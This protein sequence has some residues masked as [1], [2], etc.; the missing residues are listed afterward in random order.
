MNAVLDTTA[1]SAAEGAL[2]GVARHARSKATELPQTGTNSQIDGAIVAAQRLLDWMPPFCVANTKKA[3][4]QRAAHVNRMHK[5][6]A[7]ILEAPANTVVEADVKLHA[8]F[9]GEAM[10]Y[11]TPPIGRQRWTVKRCVEELEQVGYAEKLARPFL[12]YRNEIARL[13]AAE[14]ATPAATLRDAHAAYLEAFAAH[15][16]AL[17]AFGR[18]EGLSDEDPRY[19]AANDAVTDA[20]HAEDAAWNAFI[21]K[22]AVS[23][24]DIAFKLEC[25]KACELMR[26]DPGAASATIDQVAHDVRRLIVAPT[27]LFATSPAF[28]AALTAEIM[29]HQAHD[30]ACTV[31][32]HAEARVFAKEIAE[33]HPDMVAA[34]Q[35]H[36]ETCELSAA[37]F[38]R[39]AE[40]PATTTA[41][42]YLKLQRFAERKLYRLDEVADRPVRPGNAINEHEAMRRVVRDLLRNGP[43]NRFAPP[44]IEPFVQAASS[45]WDAA[46]GRLRAER[47]WLNDNRGL[48]VPPCYFEAVNRVLETPAPNLEALAYKIGVF[49]HDAGIIQSNLNF[50]DEVAGVFPP[51]APEGDEVNDTDAEHL[52]IIYQDVITLAGAQPGIYGADAQ[53]WDRARVAHLAAKT[54]WDERDKLDED[55]ADTLYQAYCD[56]LELF[57]A[58]PPPTVLAMV[59]QMRAEFALGG[60]LSLDYQGADCPLSMRDLLDGGDSAAQFVARFYMH[61]LRLARVSSEALN[62]PAISGMYPAFNHG[63]HFTQL[64]GAWRAHHASVEPHP[65]HLLI[66]AQAYNATE[67]TSISGD[68]AALLALAGQLRELS[69]EDYLLHGFTLNPMPDDI[70]ER[71]DA[72]A[73]ELAATRDRSRQL[74]ATTPEALRVKALFL[75]EDLPGIGLEEYHDTD[76]QLA[77]SLVADILA[78][79]VGDISVDDETN[80]WIREG[81][82]PGEAKEGAAYEAAVAALRNRAAAA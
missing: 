81:F 66:A 73:D 42:A 27:T 47:Q 4:R 55:A 58:T 26:H 71:I 39:L 9:M 37:A 64:E 28:E 53:R 62:T 46:A 17:T 80:F 30:D 69:R 7:E 33:E 21:A 52:R 60:P 14:P 67:P 31:Y 12:S 29:A 2:G 25:F 77:R 44:T 68:D 49:S 19:E 18:V 61:A 56:A 36:D 16:A 75:A 35:A 65:K 24:D 74:R 51:I 1:R 57:Q 5:A 45:L 70:Q 40:T 78:W 6:N 43:S 32:G 54:A 11:A 23:A 10:I 20:I 76:R 22:P 3:E 41:E 38:A 63:Q 13:T 34:E 59:E 82:W 72:L 79:P 15:G 8:H 48:D 50:F